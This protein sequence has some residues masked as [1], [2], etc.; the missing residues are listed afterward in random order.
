MTQMIVLTTLPSTFC[1]ASARAW[2]RTGSGTA[3]PTT[4]V[5]LTLPRR[6]V[7]GGVDQAAGG[8]PDEP[9]GD[10]GQDPRR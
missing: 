2:A 6:P 8:A 9:A 7:P 10:L 3:A 1:I 5:L 4:A